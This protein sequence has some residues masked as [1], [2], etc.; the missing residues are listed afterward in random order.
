MQWEDA[1][2]RAFE[3]GVASG[4]VEPG[5]LKPPFEIYRSTDIADANGHICTAENP[6][7][8]AAIVAV[9]NKAVRR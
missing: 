6:K 3:A 4:T 5:P 9:L 7:I 1:E 2:C 8:A